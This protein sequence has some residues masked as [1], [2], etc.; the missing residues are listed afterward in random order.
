MAFN[1]FHAFRKYRTPIFAVLTIICMGV[2]TLSFAGSPFSGNAMFGGAPANSG[3]E[4]TAFNY[5]TNWFS[6]Q[7][8]IWETTVEK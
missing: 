2:F 8:R 1:P 3:K 7:T 5:R 4:V 6:S